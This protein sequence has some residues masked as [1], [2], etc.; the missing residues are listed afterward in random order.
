MNDFSVNHE[1]GKMSIVHNAYFSAISRDEF[2]LV[3]SFNYNSLSIRRYRFWGTY[4]RSTAIFFGEDLVA[5]ITENYK[6]HEFV[7]LFHYPDETITKIKEDLFQY[8]DEFFGCTQP[9]ID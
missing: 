4:W 7:N 3:R 9:H 1:P 6:V 8:L 5:I 2:V